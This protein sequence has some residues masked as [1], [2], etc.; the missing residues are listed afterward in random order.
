[1]SCQAW[2]KRTLLLVGC[3]MCCLKASLQAIYQHFYNIIALNTVVDV[4]IYSLYRKIEILSL[5][6][7]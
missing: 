6:E 5:I 7:W 2:I 3:E 1:M 4:L